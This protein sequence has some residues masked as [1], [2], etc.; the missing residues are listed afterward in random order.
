MTSPA[1]RTLTVAA[2]LATGLGLAA[3]PVAAAPVAASSAPAVTVAAP[4][5]ALTGTL[6][7][8]RATTRTASVPVGML[9]AVLEFDGSCHRL[10]A[11]VWQGRRLVARGSRA[12]GL[13]LSGA[14]AR[15]RVRISD[16][17]PGCSG[18]WNLRLTTT[19]RVRTPRLSDVGLFRTSAS[20]TS[21]RLGASRT[22]TVRVPA[23]AVTA[24]ATASTSCRPA[25]VSLLQGRR[26]LARG[27]GRTGL[28]LGATA[29]S[30]KL[31]V[32]VLGGGCRHGWTVTLRTPAQ[33][34]PALYTTTAAPRLYA[35]ADSATAVVSGINVYRATN[36][37]V[38]YT[39]TTRQTVTPT[40]RWGL[41]ATVVGGKV[42]A[43]NDRQLTN[44]AATAIPAGGFVLSGHGTS[45]T[46]L[47]TNARLA[48]AVVVNAPSTPPTP[49]PHPTPGAHPTPL[50]RRPPPPPHPGTHHHPGTTTT[51]TPAPPPPP[52]RHPTPTDRACPT[53][54]GPGCPG[55]RGNGAAGAPS[56]P[57]GHAG[58]HRRHLERQPRRPDR[59]VVDPA[60]RRVGHLDGRPRPRRG[61]DL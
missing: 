36:A 32:Q 5:T 59:A 61:R 50:P 38:V 49:T 25:T 4:T 14:V 19:S 6:S 27:T 60:R 12:S 56:A 45:R 53:T 11:A 1:T 21:V 10:T 41:E 44:A 26:V 28:A 39:R 42:I 40:N 57:G 58:A 16:G 29:R 43:V 30:A 33:S 51:T 52:P 34:T 20:A 35:Q 9:A 54:T 8:R 23:G 2:C 22:A 17:A 55:R 46:W 18:T 37:M 31:T 47:L 7:P 48:T 24:V 15:G 3:S 13:A